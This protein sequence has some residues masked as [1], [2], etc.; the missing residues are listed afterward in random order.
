MSNNL[1]E[2]VK[3]LQNQQLLKRDMV[4]PSSCLTYKDGKLQISNVSKNPVM[5]ELLKSTG[6]TAAD[7]ELTTLLLKPL[8]AFN[9]QLAGRFEIPFQYYKRLME[10]GNV[11]LLD[12]NVNH[13]FSSIKRNYLIRCFASEDN[14]NG[15]VRAILGDRY[16]ILDNLDVLM[17]ALDAVRQSGV[18]IQIES[19][20]ITDTKMYVRFIAPD[21]VQ[22]SPNLLKNYRVPSKDKGNDYGIHAGFILTNS[23]TGHGSSFVAPRLV[24]AACRN[25]M[26][27]KQDSTNKVHLGGR[28]DEGK[29]DWS[30]ETKTKNVELIIAQVKDAVKTYTSSEYLGQTINKLEGNGAVELTHPIDAI[31]NISRDLNFSEDK[32][33]DLLAY[34]MQS[35]DLTGFGAAQAVTY[36]AHA[37]SDA[38]EQ[39]ELEAVAMD[40]VNNIE[41]YDKPAMPTKRTSQKGFSK[42]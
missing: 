28:M 29:I 33:K 7:T 35:S 13:W 1:N 30:E 31:T 32:Q 39:F 41:K 34:F 8:D 36:F 22:D 9:R 3:K 5:D 24:V 15:V 16:R 42:N 18:N 23:E 2:L 21:V 6:V 12:Q 25:G 37:K 20:D 19:A 40:I 27:M 26:I 14:T 38:D 17:A 4:V 10:D 11:P